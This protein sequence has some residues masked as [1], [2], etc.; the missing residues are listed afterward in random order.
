MKSCE[1]DVTRKSV[2]SGNP[3]NV[4]WGQDTLEDGG[5][6]GA[7]VEKIGASRTHIWGTLGAQRS[8]AEYG[9][10]F[11]WITGTIGKPTAPLETLKRGQLCI[12]ADSG[13]GWTAQHRALTGSSEA[14]W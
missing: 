11:C 10:V 14:W 4:A 8:G 6:C 1:G 7:V 13:R 5:A 9:L 3:D 2:I 12:A